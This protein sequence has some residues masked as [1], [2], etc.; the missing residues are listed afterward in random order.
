MTKLREV[1]KLKLKL[2][3]IR[4]TWKNWNQNRLVV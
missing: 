1:A 4:S 2:G 3:H